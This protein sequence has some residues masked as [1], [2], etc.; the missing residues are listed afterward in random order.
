MP[1]K[2]LQKNKDFLMN[3]P[4]V[5]SVGLCRAGDDAAIKVE[6]LRG[7]SAAGI[8]KRIEGMDVIIEPVNDME[9]PMGYYDKRYRPLQPG[10]SI[11]GGSAAFTIFHQGE[12]Y[13]ITCAHILRDGWQVGRDMHQP[14]FWPPEDDG[15]VIGSLHSYVDIYA[16]VASVPADAMAIKLLPEIAA[17]NSL[18]AQPGFIARE[19][20]EPVLGMETIHV[21]N[22][23]GQRKGKIT[24]VDVSVNLLGVGSNPRWRC[25]NLFRTDSDSRP[26]DSGGGVFS[27]D[28]PGVLGIHVSSRHSGNA[29]DACEELGFGRHPLLADNVQKDFIQLWIGSNNARVNGQDIFVDAK[30]FIT[31]RR[32]MVP[33][34]FISE[35]LGC[36]VDWDEPDQ[37]VDILRINI[38]A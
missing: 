36:T 23:S 29:T 32:T 25:D 20:I 26:G 30:P 15:G 14:T 18:I 19:I 2:M 16:P 10:A 12:F 11:Y 13:L 7:F 33:L 35:G 8:P 38:K 4:G 3:I 34:R 17:T 1:E 28:P 31:N 37:R 22:T 21:G 5:V 6:L 27:V 9:S 24:A